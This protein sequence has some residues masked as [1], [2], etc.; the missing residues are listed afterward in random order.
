MSM[1][2]RG[3]GLRTK[4]LLAILGTLALCFVAS[5]T[6]TQAIVARQAVTMKEAEL[7][8][9][10]RRYLEQINQTS[11]DNQQVAATLARAG[12]R[13]FAMKKRY[14]QLDAPTES[15][16]LVRGIL[17]ATQSPALLGGGLWFE[18]FTIDKDKKYVGPYGVV[19]TQG[20]VDE[21]WEY[22]DDK[23]DYPTQSWYTLA[24]PADWDR[25]KPRNA[26]S[27]RTEPY[28]DK[29]DGVPTVFVT[30]DA[31]MVDND[32]GRIVG[33]AT[34]DWTLTSLRD[35]LG[36]FKVTPSSFAFLVDLQS[37][38][39][40]YSP[41]EAD[42]FKPL[43]ETAW[44]KFIP[45]SGL[46]EG[47]LQAKNQLSLQSRPFDALYARTSGDFVFGFFVAHDEAYAA[48]KTIRDRNMLLAAAT[49]LITALV[50]FLLITK[51]ISPIAA[52]Q[53][54]VRLVASGDLDQEVKVETRD[55]IGQLAVDIAKMTK[56]LKKSYTH[57]EARVAERTS[58]LNERNQAMRLVLD[59]VE[60]G[61]LSIDRQGRVSEE[62]S[63]IV[64]RWFGPCGRGI[65]FAE[66]LR[67]HAPDTAE[68]FA[69]G[70]E[71]VLDGFM[72]LEL[73]LDQLAKRMVIGDRHFELAYRPIL[74]DSAE[75]E[76]ANCLVVMTDITSD[77]ERERIEAEQHETVQL[78]ERIARDRAGVVEFATEARRMVQLITGS[79]IKSLADMKRVVHTL[80]GNAGIF[81]I[82]RVA[83]HCHEMEIEMEETKGL[84]TVAMRS[85]LQTRWAN[86]DSRLDL[87]LGE[88]AGRVL[89]IDDEEYRGA[90]AALRA[91]APNSV[92]V[93]RID[94]WTLEPMQKRLA[95][96]GEQVT[97]LA[98]RLGKSVR[99]DIEAGR[100][101]L[102]AEHWGAFW[103][104]F[105]HVVRNAVDHGLETREE[106]LAAG[107]GAE[108]RVVLRTLRTE[109]ALHIEIE[110]DGRGVNWDRLAQKAALLGLPASTHEDRVRAM[111]SDGVSTRDEAS[112]L[113][114][115][116]VGAGAVL[117]ECEGR[118]GS[119]VV[120]SELGKGTCFSFVF[121]VA[122]AMMRARP[123]LASV[124]PKRVASVL[125]S[126]S[127][128]PAQGLYRPSLFP[129]RPS[130]APGH[131]ALSPF[132]PPLLPSE[133]RG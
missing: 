40:L 37:R 14:S 80:K 79:S 61:F 20:Q 114:G 4:A 76:L 7:N 130:Q 101:R 88:R 126:H 9:E 71:A 31:V 30:T 53:R 1:E 60:Q 28:E 125:P 50:C 58:E 132:A 110:D 18:P 82:T 109:D 73:C 93:E 6:I 57:L 13:L 17:A 84:P 94:A 55:E 127:Y 83:S 102:D 120:R 62:R 111:F 98:T 45:L 21:D 97:G 12:E 39:V 112:E 63:A 47:E 81:G 35:A 85:E 38:K 66:Y 54:S 105:V 116:G 131:L 72:P 95:R 117:R 52:L 2:R 51:F 91:G 99:V 42:N 122:E 29:L 3:M 87:W 119:V 44:G 67:P 90:L 34:A 26:T 129:V 121:P 22:N 19:K 106:R 25:A 108:G 123:Q 24:L 115:R 70:W 27:F 36:K 11:L 48:L 16:G 10:V 41:N 56:E 5:T 74:D 92:V 69:L 23:Y 64:D 96:I 75:A 89:E 43:E 33:V 113:S 65:T 78:F 133:S 107:K 68:M 15:M 86:V 49:L 118:G 103:G 32:T 46:R 100:V 128:R 104:S 124:A 8:S 77:V 59:N